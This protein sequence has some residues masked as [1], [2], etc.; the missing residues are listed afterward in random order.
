MEV[1]P[2]RESAGPDD[3]HVDRVRGDGDET[4]EE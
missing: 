2:R 1:L 3:K 4:V